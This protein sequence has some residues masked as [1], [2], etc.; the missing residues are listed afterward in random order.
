MKRYERIAEAVFCRPWAI[1][2][3]Y[4][5]TICRVVADRLSGGLHLEFPD[6]DE[7]RFNDDAYQM[8]NVAVIPVYGVMAKRMN[9][10]MAFSGGTSTEIVGRDFEEA[11]NDRT[12]EAIVLDIDSPGGTVDGSFTLAEKVYNARGQKPIVAFVNGMATSAAY[13][14]ASAAD[15]I[16]GQRLG[17]VGSIGIYT[18]HVDYSQANEQEGIRVTYIYAGEYKV[19]ANEDEALAQDGLEY[20]Q[21]FVDRTYKDFVDDV[22]RNRGLDAQAVVDTKARVYLEDEALALGLIDTVGELPGAITLASNFNKG[23][24][25]DAILE[26]EEKSSE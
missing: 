19:T 21:G 24:L 5:Q 23:G 3:Q 7:R 15:V 18:T 2:P 11:L 14:L 9:M 6:K 17:M 22:A 26:R 13:L 10:I 1:L 20:L 16:V 12:V 4:H 8:G 25:A